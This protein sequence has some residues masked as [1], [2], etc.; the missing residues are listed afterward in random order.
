MTHRSVPADALAPPP[1]PAPSLSAAAGRLAASA[2]D[3]DV[4]LHAGQGQATR[5]LSLVGQGMALL[6][7]GVHM[8]NAPFQATALGLQAAVQMARL[9]AAALG[10]TMISPPPSDHR[11]ADPAWS[12]P[13]F[14][15]LSQSFLLMEEW[16]A[17][18]A[19]RPA[20]V[21]RGNQR[22]V[23]FLFR[24]LADI[25]SP[26]NLPWL[27]PEVIR[28]T[29]ACGGR[30]FL[31]GLV[32]MLADLRD[33]TAGN[34]R[35]S[36]GFRIGQDL[37][38]TPGQVVL[39]NE[40]IE[41]IQ[42]T[43]TTSAVRAKPVLIVPA[44][45]MKYYILDLSKTNSLIRYLVDQGYTVF[46]ISWRNP[47]AAMRD[48]TMDDY[49]IRGVMAALDA[50]TDVCGG[51]RVQACGY[52]LGGTLLSIAAAAMARDGDDRLASMTLF[53]AQTDFTE[54]GELQL[55]ITEDQ[56]AFLDDVMRVQGYLD[57][58]QMAGS[59]QLL[60]ANDLIW[61]RMIRSYM[62]GEPE[63]PSDLMA[64]NADGTRMPARM[65][66]EY[67]HRLFLDNELA[68]GRFPASGRPVALNDIHVPLFVVAT[69]TDHIAPWR[70]VYKISL[71]ND[72]DL[73]FV[74]ASGGHNAGV[75]SEPGHPHRHFRLARRVAGGLYVPPDEWQAKAA[76]RPG[77][78]WPAWVQWLDEQAG[79]PSEPPPLGSKRYAPLEAA[80]GRYVHEH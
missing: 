59:F 75:V 9:P 55:F 18:V 11:F 6:D 35:P 33:L 31:H 28:T 57:S 58:R 47:D 71:L 80:P 51:Q 74:L 29:T 17:Q 37:A 49:R 2:A 61:S 42:Y 54:A 22:V 65:H 24:Q 68:E 76:K 36:H 10:G 16:L 30:N 46:A 1:A 19:A 25:V 20:G 34:S 26:S 3:L 45:I 14:S 21:S 56:L 72:S 63:H 40:L 66:S 41:L 27:N 64:W 7:W 50:V 70:S 5:G 32:H 8:A 67:L 53:C 15:V 79:P 12:Q 43:P 44:W 69:E 52:C 73:V 78:W 38:A 48:T 39:R 62:L 23:S 60:R 13:P 4:L 77:S